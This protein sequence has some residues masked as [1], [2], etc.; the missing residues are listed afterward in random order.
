MISVKLQPSQQCSPIFSGENSVTAAPDAAT[1]IQSPMMVSVS[2][3]GASVPSVYYSEITNLK[4]LHISVNSK[5]VMFDKNLQGL[6]QL[7][8]FVRFRV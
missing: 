6:K 7:S 1:S 4:K 5:S 3:V 8:G 2:S